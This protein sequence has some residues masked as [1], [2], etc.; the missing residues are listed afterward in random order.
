MTDM[1]MARALAQRVADQGGRVYY[2][3]GFV[4]DRL[5]GVENKDVDVEV[6]GITPEALEAILDCLGTRLEMGSSFGVYGLKGYDLD[7]AMPRREQATGR[8]HKD[9]QVDVDPFIGTEKAA[10]RRDFTINALME[11]VLTG[12]VVDHFHGQEDLRNGIIRHVNDVS[13]PE[14]ALRVLR[15]AQFGA[16]FGFSVA[17]ETVELSRKLDLS[18]LPRERV[19]GEA[20]KALLK[21]KKPSV[22]FEVLREMGQLSYWFPEVEALYGVAQ[23]PR[24]HGEGDVWTHTMMV[25][26]AAAERRKQTGYPLG[27]MLSALTHDFGK[28]VC[29]EVIN[30]DIHAYHHETL[31]LPLVETFLKRLTREKNLIH[32][33]LNMVELHMRPNQMAMQSS[34]KA[35]NK[36]FDQSVAPEDLIHLASCDNL[37]SIPD[38]DRPSRE[39]ALWE[40]LAVYRE[41]MSRPY[42]MGA[43]LIAAGLVPG[44]DFRE[45]MDF[46]HK[47]RL[48]GV[49]KEDAL[50]QT[51]AMAGIRREKP[52]KD[53][54]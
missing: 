11:D 12:E 45:M 20:E 43:D 19:L 3:G 24:F 34:I 52:K 49:K 22:F 42:V 4:R 5:T 31:G 17:P 53:K 8:G 46:A 28:A 2:V 30:G 1:E 27:F 7:I 54:K 44:P 36:L 33:V 23:S 32:Y 47:L 21:G 10:M 51:L 14:D 50:R 35:T 6:H 26:D 37:G 29:S 9:F 18:V 41:Y 40:R 13:F 48:A 39:P 15:G 25:L 16:R 38:H